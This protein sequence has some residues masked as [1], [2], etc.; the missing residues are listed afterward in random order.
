[1][2]LFEKI[3][4]TLFTPYIGS[5]T[6]FQYML[7]GVGITL[8]LTF[9]ALILGTVIGVITAFL[10]IG[11]SHGL[12]TAKQIAQAAKSHRYPSGMI[13]SASLR[14]LGRKLA[15][16]YIWV[17]RGTPVVVQLLIIYFAIFASVDISQ[18]LVG[19]VAFGLNSGAYIS[20]IIRAGILAVD[21]GQTEAS[22]SLGIS[23]Q[24]TMVHII[25]PQAIKNILPALG[26]EFIVLLKETAVVGMIALVDLMFAANKIRAAKYEAYIPLV[27]AALMYLCLTTI[28][29]AIIKRVERR[30]QTSD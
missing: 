4:E 16:L 15:S 22:R 5:Q 27:T 12:D 10:R 25:L 26:N 20:E 8:Q 14:Y 23:S 2:S 28:L 19:V 21:K 11:S 9:F 30:L 3:Q 24:S 7:S 17:I 29:A 1:M 6:G 18:V 13:V